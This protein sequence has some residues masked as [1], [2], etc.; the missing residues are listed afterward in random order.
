MALSEYEVSILYD[1]I[2]VSSAFSIAGSLFIIVSYLAFPLERKAHSQLI[3]WLSICDLGASGTNTFLNVIY[4]TK[5]SYFALP[6][7]RSLGYCIAQGASIQF[8][9]ISSFC[10]TACIAVSLYFILVQKKQGKQ[11]IYAHNVQRFQAST[12]GIIF[13]VGQ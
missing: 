4:S 10:W 7:Q 2:R 5:V 8:F 11:S 13:S 1:I 3:F 6:I 12:N 9:Q